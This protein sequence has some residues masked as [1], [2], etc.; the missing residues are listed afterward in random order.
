MNRLIRLYTEVSQY[1]CCYPLTEKGTQEVGNG[2][3]CTD[4]VTAD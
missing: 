2:Q 4:A 3:P 1:F